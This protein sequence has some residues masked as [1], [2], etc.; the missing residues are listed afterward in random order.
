MNQ[1]LKIVLSLSLS[2]TLVILLICLCTLLFKNT[3]SKGWRYYIWVIAV[4]RLLLPF[5]PAVNLTGGVYQEMEQAVIQMYAVTEKNQSDEGLPLQ[6]EGVNVENVDVETP[7]LAGF[8]QNLWV[9]WLMGAL[10]LLIRKITVYQSFVKFTK[11]GWEEVTDILLLDRAAELEE[12]LGIKKA[13][14]LRVNPMLSSPV[15]IG[16][17]RPCIVL[18]TA[19][20]PEAEFQYTI[21]HELVHYKRKD[22]LYKWLV[23]FTICMHW[24][25]PLVYW[26][27]RE[28]GR[29][30][31]LSCDEAVIGHLD[32]KQ[33]EAYGDTLLNAVACG[34]AYK[35]SVASVTLHESKKQLKERLVAIMDYKAKSKPVRAA[36]L[37]TAMAL[38][39]GASAVGA[40]ASPVPS[41]TAIWHGTG[42]WNGETYTYTQSGYY[43]APYIFQIGWNVNGKR[44]DAYPDKAELVLADRNTITVSFDRSCKQYI[45]DQNAMNALNSLSGKLKS[46]HADCDLPFE[47]PLVVSVEYVG[48]ESLE[49]LA[50]EYY[51]DGSLVSF[52]AIFPSLPGEVQKS[53]CDRMFTDGKVGFFSAVMRETNNALADVYVDR[54]YREEKLALYA[55]ILGQ[56]NGALANVYMEKA[57]RDQKLTYFASAAPYLTDE[58]REA[59]IVRCSRDK[60]N[61]YLAVLTKEA[62]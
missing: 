6:E 58:A 3:F 7:V 9:V 40:Y 15:L 50:E 24:F 1:I 21:Q 55:S 18:P 19:S 26:M 37:L 12:Q 28:T 34:G 27:G 59:W 56:T 31:E 16:F 23:Q 43:E 52:V 39:V 45:A 53:F 41:S 30:C 46:R 17:F 62:G 47:K 10:A 61:T 11:A 42:Q 60:R 25:N 44:N 5:A 38:C 4:L 32:G 51:A 22:M 49:K 20:L 57:Y 35:N 8:V 2:G 36:A 54:A 29:A 33:R 14:E 13:V 48:G